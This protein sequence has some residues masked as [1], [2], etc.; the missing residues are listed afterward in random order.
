MFKIEIKKMHLA[1][2]LTVER[3]KIKSKARHYRLD[4]IFKKKYFDWSKN[5]I[6]T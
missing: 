1:N 2:T 5:L 4:K 3:V 6:V